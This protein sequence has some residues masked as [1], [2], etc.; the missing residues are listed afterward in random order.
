VGVDDI[1]AIFYLLQRPDID[2]KAIT[3]ASTGNAHC[4]PALR[5]VLG[6]LTLMKHNNIPVECGPLNPLNGQH[7]FPASVLE[8]ADTL[9]GTAKLLPKVTATSQQKGVELLI[10]T[11]Q[12]SKEPVTI[13]AIGPL[14]NIAEALQRA[15]KIKNNIKAIY[16]L[17]GAI[18]VPG[19]LS[20]VGI[21][22]SNKTAEW[23]IY[24]DPIA[25]AIV[26]NQSIP[27]ILVPLDAT[28]SVPIDIDFYKKLKKNHRTP[29]ANFV[30]TLL[31]K[32]LQI[33]SAQQWYFWD[34]LSAV[35]ASDE[36]MVSFMT[37]PLRVVLAPESQSGRIVI[38]PVNGTNTRIVT[39]VNQ[40]KFKETLLIGLNKVF[41]ESKKD[42]S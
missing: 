42:I 36:S 21:R 41:R 7:H 30:F 29:A 2:V 9:A 40:K 38:D 27:I 18:N 31:K 4:L 10:E 35:I 25:A 11:I 5:N 15:P 22:H 28:N 1:I 37:Q 24:I 13:L 20:S 26:L 3:I 39:H 14:T 32:N 16:I 6:L 33:I 34:P 17:G 12:K 19:N 8:E 23:N